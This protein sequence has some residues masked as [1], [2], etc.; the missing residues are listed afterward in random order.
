LQTE[1]EGGFVAEHGHSLLIER[2]KRERLSLGS[3]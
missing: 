3:L 1:F 2:G